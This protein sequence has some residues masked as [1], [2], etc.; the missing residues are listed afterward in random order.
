[1]FEN[2]IDKKLVFAG[3]KK[4][5]AKSPQYIVLHHSGASAEQTVEQIH[6]F[7]LGKGWI[8]IGYNALVDK[9]GAVYWGRGIEYI[10]AHCKGL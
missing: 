10:G 4:K 3:T 9:N 8:G 1:M 7:H 6:S 2:I 5:F